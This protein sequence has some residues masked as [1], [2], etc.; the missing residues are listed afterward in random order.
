M[1]TVYL[2]ETTVGGKSAYVKLN[3]EVCGYETVSL[4]T[5]GDSLSR[6]WIYRSGSGSQFIAKGDYFYKF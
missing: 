4:V 2:K 1:Y 6:T 3:I 5:P